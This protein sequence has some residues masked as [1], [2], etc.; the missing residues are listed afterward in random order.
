MLCLVRKSACCLSTSDISEVSAVKS[1][2]KL[3]AV[4]AEGHMIISISRKSQLYCFK[5]E[6]TF[7]LEMQVPSATEQSN[8]HSCDYHYDN[9]STKWNHNVGL[10]IERFRVSVDHMKGLNGAWNEQN[11]LLGD[12]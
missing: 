2:L 6:L 1:R 9:H 4:S 10:L 3:L 7:E 8:S 5:C 12:L 11:V